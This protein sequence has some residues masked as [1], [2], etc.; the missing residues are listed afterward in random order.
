MPSY[1]NQVTE[2]GW[3]NQ[4][5]ADAINE[6]YKIVDSVNKYTGNSAKVY[7][8]NETHYVVVDAVTNKVVQVSDLTKEI[9]EFT[10]GNFTK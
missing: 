2:R 4:K 7:F 1:K 5:I 9:W 10:P 3:T 6:P 8:I